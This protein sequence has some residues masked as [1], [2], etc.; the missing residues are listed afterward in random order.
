ML[1]I[2]TFQFLANPMLSASVVEIVDLR[3]LNAN[4][5][6]IADIPANGTWHIDASILDVLRNGDFN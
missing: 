2:I 3:K 4:I 5:C 6:Q 1:Q